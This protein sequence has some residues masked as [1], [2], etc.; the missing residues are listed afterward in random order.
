DAAIISLSF[1]NHR[2]QR[3]Q[4][5]LTKPVSGTHRGWVTVRLGPID[6]PADARYAVIGCH[7]VP[8]RTADI[9]GAAWFDS[10]RLMKL[11]QMD[12]ISNFQT[13]FRRH[14]APIEVHA[15]VSGL[16]DGEAYSV[17]LR[18]YDGTGQRLAET[19]QQIT[20]DDPAIAEVPRLQTPV[21]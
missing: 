4:R 15:N 20:T 5:V 16:D 13:H 21:A 2:S 7:L 3:V 11:P 10:I 8:G 9:G 19:S 14:S 17:H 6:P 12:L 18:I 1:L